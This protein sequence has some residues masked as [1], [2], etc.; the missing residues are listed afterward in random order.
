MEGILWVQGM[1]W[2]LNSNGTG[3]KCQIGAANGTSNF[4][5]YIQLRWAN[6]YFL[7]HIQ[8]EVGN[9]DVL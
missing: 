9:S 3:T 8:C 7:R 1:F 2:F 4:H 6:L 5:I